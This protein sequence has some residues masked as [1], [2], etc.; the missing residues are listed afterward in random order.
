MCAGRLCWPK[1]PYISHFPSALTCAMPS[2][3]LHSTDCFV[4]VKAAKC[5]NSS[6]MMI[7][8]RHSV[9]YI[10][11]HT[12]CPVSPRIQ[13][14]LSDVQRNRKHADLLTVSVLCLGSGLFCLG[15][16][17]TSCD[18]AFIAAS[19]RF[20]Q[21]K[22]PRLDDIQCHVANGFRALAR[23]TCRATPNRPRRTR[24]FCQFS[25]EQRTTCSLWLKL[26]LL[27][28]SVHVTRWDP[29]VLNN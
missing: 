18:S 13:W 25:T 27:F 17:A 14:L 29:P 15:S 16:S 11:G 20:W 4:K 21:R 19:Q 2:H 12:P 7:I 22:S 23:K 8:I 5:F 3:M 1:L 6:Q 26:I 9:N 28:A 24:T 10:L